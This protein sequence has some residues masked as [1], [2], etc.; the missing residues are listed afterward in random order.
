MLTFRNALSWPPNG[1]YT[2]ASSRNQKNQDS[3]RK[4]SW[5]RM[6]VRFQLKITLALCGDATVTVVTS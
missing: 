4:P 6:R 1:T 2:S 3:Q 5:W